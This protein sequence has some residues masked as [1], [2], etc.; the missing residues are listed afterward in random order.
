MEK[1]DF[2]FCDNL[3]KKLKDTLVTDENKVVVKIHGGLG[4]Q[5][6]QYAFGRAYALKYTKK[7]FLD[8]S[9]GVSWSKT[10]RPYQLDVFNINAEILPE[11]EVGQWRARLRF[12][13]FLRKLL[14]FR[15]YEEPPQ[16]F[17][18]NPKVA[19]TGNYRYLSGRFASDRYFEGFEDTIC[20]DFDFRFSPSLANQM[21]IDKIT[22]EN[23]VGIHVRC[24]PYA[25]T[26]NFSEIRGMCSF[27]YY[28]SAIN[29]IIRRVEK[30]V[31]YIFSDN[32]QWVK[33]NFKIS[34][35]TT[36]V[37]L[38]EDKNCFEDLRLMSLC[39][40]NIMANSFFSWWAAWLNKNRH[41]IIIAPEKWFH[42]KDLDVRDLIPENWI[43]M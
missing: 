21:L 10:K 18:Y 11:E 30:P 7:L 19:E 5:M 31:F 34:Y 33:E 16:K 15:I 20:H 1:S 4:R 40:H 38:N 28:M 14:G 2:D 13:V 27:D 23:S 9:S 29:Y 3:K 32:P 8:I 37:T 6:F 39:K 24:K 36:V 25:Y 35:P 42:T 43:K 12:P 41:K 26:K 22:S 17:R